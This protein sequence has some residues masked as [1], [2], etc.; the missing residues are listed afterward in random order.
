MSTTTST[1]ST[2]HLLPD[3]GTFYKANLHC[4]STCSDGR[5]SPERL[6]EA[7][8]AKGYSAIA[9]TDHN[10]YVDHQDLTDESFVALNGMEIGLMEPDKPWRFTKV[11]H[12]N[13]IDTCPWDNTAIK[14]VRTENKND[15]IYHR[16]TMDY[17]DT[18]AIGQYIKYM[19]E[20]GFLV[21]YNHP[22]WSL[23]D[24]RDYAGLE[25]LFAME[26]YNHKCENDGHYGSR[27]HVY[28]EMLRAGQKISCICADDNHNKVPFD[29]K[30]ND[31]FGGYTMIK[32]KELSYP[33][34][35]SALKA[36]H[37]Y[38][39]E[40]EGGPEIHKLTL[41]GHTVS[42]TCSPVNKIFLLTNGRHAKRE[43]AEIGGTLSSATLELAGDEEYFRIVCEDSRGRC[44]YSNAYFLEDIL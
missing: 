25:H 21:T 38:A 7:Y 11:Y 17:S 4:H 41:T 39:V 22:G 14:Q 26:L 40:G 18:K 12:L 23:Q 9:Y 5:L 15:P 20:L 44:A 43:L 8:Q 31:S 3:T 6:K 34:L 32:A 33:G 16:M 29:H 42:V 13:M 24:Y 37:F 19:S 36:R 27:A 28:D 35:I 2:T 1:I 10:I 30:E